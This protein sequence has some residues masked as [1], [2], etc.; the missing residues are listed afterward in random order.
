MPFCVIAILRFLHHKTEPELTDLRCEI[1]K[2]KVPL[3]VTEY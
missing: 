1:T 3:K 2:E